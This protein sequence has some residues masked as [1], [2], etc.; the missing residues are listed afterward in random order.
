MGSF[1][2]NKFIKLLRVAPL[3]CSLSIN[4]AI[5]A[6]ELTNTVLADA[7]LGVVRSTGGDTNALDALSKI[8]KKI[9][10]D[11]DGISRAE[12][13]AAEAAYAAKL[14]AR[15]I[16]QVLS[17]DLNGDM[18][19]T[20][21][22]II[23][24]YQTIIPATRNFPKKPTAQIQ[25]ELRNFVS[26][27]LASDANDNQ[28]LEGKELYSAGARD[29]WVIHDFGGQ[30]IIE[31]SRPFFDLAFALFDA[32]PNH[33]S[34]LSMSEGLIVMAKVIGSNTDV[35]SQNWPS[36]SLSGI[37]TCPQTKLS[38]ESQLSYI[39]TSYGSHISPVSLAGPDKVTYATT[40]HIED[41]TTP[42]SIAATSGGPMIWKFTGN[43]E[44]IE[45][46][47]VSTQFQDRQTG[48]SAVGVVGIPAE[49]LVVVGSSC[50]SYFGNDLQ[51]A[52]AN[53]SDR[54]LQ[55]TGKRPSFVN[56]PR[57]DTY[58][59]SLPSGEIFETRQEFSAIVRSLFKWAKQ[60]P[61]NSLAQLDNRFIDPTERYITGPLARY[62]G[63]LMN[64]VD[65]FRIQD[66][67]SPSKKEEYEVLPEELG[68]F[69]LLL[70]N[71]ITMLG[72]DSHG[73]VLVN[74]PIL[75]PPGNHQDRFLLGDGVDLPLGNPG[76]GCLFSQ[77]GKVVI[78]GN[79]CPSGLP[80]R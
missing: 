52:S 44:R 35:K 20:V 42:V 66:V 60:H 7:Y 62:Q 9:D 48:T 70:A 43:T 57:G 64:V 71:K 78:D 41:G 77:D 11:N 22:E 34:K 47:F 69:Q 31:E 38:E 10:I 23:A 67:V 56:R 65:D 26:E 27:Y 24:A 58:S 54:L 6:E 16:Q 50:M 49:K 68:I 72:N 36:Y 14:R 29:A 8:F 79:A 39:S 18:I 5:S 33:D 21:E 32:D 80:V 74:A 17:I 40:V 46:V 1:V 4:A 30:N 76:G 53:I 2:A 19:I 59:V 73:A 25:R 37:R 55:V 75:Y 61:E 3:I 15:T 63:Y 13:E 28:S 45:K 51:Q 12:L